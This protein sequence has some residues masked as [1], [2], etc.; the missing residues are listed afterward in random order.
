[1]LN[2]QKAVVFSDPFTPC[3]GSGFDFPSIERNGKIS[4]KAVFTLPASMAH[5]ALIG[6]VFGQSYGL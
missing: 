4:D 5:H 1:M 3:G 2:L 6:M